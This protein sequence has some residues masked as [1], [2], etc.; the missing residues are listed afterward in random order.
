MGVKWISLY[1]LLVFFF[2]E[3]LPFNFLFAPAQPAQPALPAQPAQLN[4]WVITICFTFNLIYSTASI[5]SS[6]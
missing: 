5:V 4:F 1:R 3:T 6:W 2:S